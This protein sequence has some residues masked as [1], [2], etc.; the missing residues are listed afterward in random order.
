ME[1]PETANTVL[2]QANV[3]AQI[4]R[5]ILKSRCKFKFIYTRLSTW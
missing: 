2:E 4:L 5:V 1:I 3:F